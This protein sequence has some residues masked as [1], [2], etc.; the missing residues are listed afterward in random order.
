MFGG[1]TIN[2]EL[3][4]TDILQLVLVL[5]YRLDDYSREKIKKETDVHEDY[6]NYVDI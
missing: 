2:M 4:K 1:L 3:L 6:T 5:L